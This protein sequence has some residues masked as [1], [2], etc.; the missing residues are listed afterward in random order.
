MCVELLVY[1]TSLLLVLFCMVAWIRTVVW[2]L[3]GSGSDRTPEVTRAVRDEED[4]EGDQRTA[5]WP[6][7]Q[8]PPPPKRDKQAIAALSDR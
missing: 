8:A 4:E 5:A 1:V 2:A 3:F 6:L 7:R